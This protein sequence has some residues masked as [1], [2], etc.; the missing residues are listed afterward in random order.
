M[1]NNVI[2]TMGVTV[3]NYPSDFVFSTCMV[4]IDH[5]SFFSQK[6]ALL[7]SNSSIFVF[8]VPPTL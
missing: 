8:T 5:T 3:K 4:G 7:P 1:D 6:S 2:H